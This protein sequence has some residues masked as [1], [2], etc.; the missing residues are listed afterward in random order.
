[1]VRVR[2]W[3]LLSL[4]LS[5]APYELGARAADTQINKAESF[6]RA[7]AP[8]M[9]PQRVRG[10]KNGIEEGGRAFAPLRGIRLFVPSH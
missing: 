8:S 5:L 2:N 4:S 9:A 6:L 1:M 3:I 10:L 7:D